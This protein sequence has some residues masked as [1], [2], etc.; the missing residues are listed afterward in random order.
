MKE[1]SHSNPQIGEFNAHIFPASPA[2]TDETIDDIRAAALIECLKNAAK[3]CELR[4]EDASLDAIL[5]AAPRVSLD[6]RLYWLVWFVRKH[7]QPTEKGGQKAALSLAIDDPTSESA[8]AG[9][10]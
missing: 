8:S 2:H 6:P 9:F 4:F 5:K 3:D 7:F 1:Y 10:P